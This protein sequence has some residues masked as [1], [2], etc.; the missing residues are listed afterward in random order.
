MGRAHAGRGARRGEIAIDDG[1]GGQRATD[2]AEREGPHWQAEHL[3]HLSEHVASATVLSCAGD[4][5][6]GSSPRGSS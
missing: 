3:A 6:R 2:D 1:R 5:E 4:G